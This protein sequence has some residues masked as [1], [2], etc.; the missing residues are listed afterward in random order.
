M[1]VTDSGWRHTVN[2]VWDAPQTEGVRPSAR[3]DHTAALVQE[4]VYVLGGQDGS[5]Q[6]CH[7]VFALRTTGA[8]LFWRCVVPRTTG[9]ATTPSPTS[10]VTEHRDTGTASAAAP[11]VPFGHASTV[12]GT[13]VYMF[14][15][16]QDSSG[17]WHNTL[18]SFDTGT[19]PRTVAPVWSHS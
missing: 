9:G 3:C 6:P 12:V 7:D 19:A 18:L 10:R 16:A 13:R 5:G 8:V 15:G 17:R 4:T 11:R 14:G 1:P 2:L